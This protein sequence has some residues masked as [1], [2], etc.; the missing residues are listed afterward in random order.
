MKLYVTA[1]GEILNFQKTFGH[2]MGQVK[3]SGQCN[4][5]EIAGLRVDLKA[6]VDGFGCS[7]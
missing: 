6:V 2:T 4:G 5:K 3:F 7:G 1:F